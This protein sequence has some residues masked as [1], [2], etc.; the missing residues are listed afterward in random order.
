MG[1]GEGK[2]QQGAGFYL[3]EV[4]NV[5]QR[6]ADKE[7]WKRGMDAGNVY[8][9]NIPDESLNVFA[10]YELPISAQS[11]N[12]QEAVRKIFGEKELRT[13]KDYFGW[14]SIDDAPFSAVLRALDI[15]K[16]NDIKKS[17]QMFRQMGVPGATYAD[18]GSR[19]AGGSGTR[20]IV[21]WDQDVLDEAARRGVKKK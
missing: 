2:Q 5:A 18:A 1:T 15:E 7:A 4:Q 13:L 19:G 17:A 12:V 16:G 3:A 10:K 6:M 8:E 11:K 21:V 20:N 9:L 14:E